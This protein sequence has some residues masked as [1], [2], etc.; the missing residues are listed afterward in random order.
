MPKKCSEGDEGQRHTKT[1]CRLEI[2]TQVGWPIGNNLY[3]NKYATGFLMR[4]RILSQF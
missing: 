4:R 1:L 2:F 3:L